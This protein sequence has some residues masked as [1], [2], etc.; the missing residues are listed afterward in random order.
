MT[1]VAMSAEQVT[2]LEAVDLDVLAQEAAPKA[3]PKRKALQRIP[4]IDR[5]LTV[6]GEWLLN[7]KCSVV[8]EVGWGGSM[9]GALIDGGGELIRCTAKDPGG[10]PDDVYDTNKAVEAL[11]DKLKQVVQVQYLDLTSS[12]EQKAEQCGCARRTYFDRLAKAHQ[13]IL[14][15]LKAP[16]NLRS[17]SK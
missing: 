1:S 3:K 14:F 12:A 5:R 4:G 8:G 10:M 17:R 16:S 2:R 15:R 6:W 9:L 7:E 13:E 11:S